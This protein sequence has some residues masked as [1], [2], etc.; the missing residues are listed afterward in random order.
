MDTMEMIN[1]TA[2]MLWYDQYITPKFMGRLIVAARIVCAIYL[3]S[4]PMT[5][6]SRTSIKD[7]TGDAP[8]EI[9]REDEDLMSYHFMIFDTNQLLPHELQIS[10][11]GFM[12]I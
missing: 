5:S 6:Q 11:I 10:C 4:R 3:P 8:V 9:K 12:V 1:R 7:A 2:T